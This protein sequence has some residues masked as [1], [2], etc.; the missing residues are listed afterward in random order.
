MVV[1][2]GLQWLGADR[3]TGVNTINPQDMIDDSELVECVNFM[4]SEDGVLSKLS[5]NLPFAEIN[6]N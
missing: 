4:F 2:Q 5:A 3:F 6:E 1:P